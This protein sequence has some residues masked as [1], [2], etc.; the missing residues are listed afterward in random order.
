MPETSIRRVLRVCYERDIVC[1]TEAE[2][3]AGLTP[4]AALPRLQRRRVLFIS[5]E[6][7]DARITAATELDLNLRD[8]ET[9]TPGG[10][11]AIQVPYAATMN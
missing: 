5:E 2:C 11:N 3:G 8:C 7:I 1:I 6:A 9:D 10:A 4:P